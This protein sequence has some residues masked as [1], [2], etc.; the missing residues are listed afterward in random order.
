ML[1][2]VKEPL[3]QTSLQS[4]RAG[5]APTQSPS[6]PPP[7]KPVPPPVTLEP[8]EVIA[9]KTPLEATHSGFTPT[10][11]PSQQ[12]GPEVVRTRSESSTLRM[13]VN[14]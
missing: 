6:K 3:P 2:E 4:T 14:C 9:V 5:Y 13:C 7:E 12:S 1:E 11:S 10:Q 8:V